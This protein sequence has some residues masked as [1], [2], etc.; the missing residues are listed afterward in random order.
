MVCKLCLLSFAIYFW[1]TVFQV[2]LQKNWPLRT[3]CTL[4]YCINKKRHVMRWKYMFSCC[5]IM[6]WYEILDY[7]KKISHKKMEILI[8]KKKKLFNRVN[9]WLALQCSAIHSSLEQDSGIQ[10][11]KVMCRAEQFSAAQCSVVHHSAVWCNTVQ[12][13]ASQSSMMQHSAV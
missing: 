6:R 8:Q 9:V 1:K 7:L 12:H 10:Y 11:R 13:S 4:Y 5:K 3:L 2:L